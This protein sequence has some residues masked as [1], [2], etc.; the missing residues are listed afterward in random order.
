MN[1]QIHTR[2]V[3]IPSEVRS[4]VEDQVNKLGKYVKNLIGIHVDISKD[5]HHKKGEVFRIECNVHIPRKIIRG[6]KTGETLVMALGA[7]EKILKVKVSEEN[8]KRI[9]KKKRVAKEG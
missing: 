5:T 6:I 8:K 4:A 3:K 7:V 9:D 1:I 2:N